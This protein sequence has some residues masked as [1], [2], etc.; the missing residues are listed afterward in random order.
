MTFP[1]PARA[2]AAAAGTAVAVLAALPAPANA[3]AGGTIQFPAGTTVVNAHSGKC[4]EIA[5]W[6]TDNGAP[7]RQWTASFPNWDGNK[8][9]ITA[10]RPG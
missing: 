3:A 9:W 5:D 8:L 2:R 10:V 1:R 4:L 7:A 6:R